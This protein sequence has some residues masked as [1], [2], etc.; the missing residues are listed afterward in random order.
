MTAGAEPSPPGRTPR[1]V[2][3]DLARAALV[4]LTALAVSPGCAGSAARTGSDAPGG[5]GPQAEPG[6]EAA[7]LAAGPR[8]T[9]SYVAA[10]VRVVVAA[11]ASQ[12]GI[13]IDIDGDVDVDRDLVDPDFDRRDFVDPDFDPDFDRDVEGD[14]GGRRDT[15]REEAPRSW[16]RLHVE[17]DAGGRRVTTALADRPWDEALAAI[18]CAAGLQVVERA[19][20]LVAGEAPTGGAPWSPR[21]GA[22][23][24]SGADRPGTT[25]APG[26]FAAALATPID[27]DLVDASLP[28]A[29]VA[30]ERASG[31]PFAAAPGLE[32]TVTLR[33]QGIPVGE[34]AKL[35][36]QLVGCAIVREPGAP[37]TF[38]PRECG[39]TIQ[40]G[41]ADRAVLLALV[42]GYAEVPLVVGP[43]PE[44]PEVAD[45]ASVTLWGR[46]DREAVVDLA[47][48]AGLV[49]ELR[50][51]VVL[52]GRVPRGWGAPIEPRADR[53]PVPPPEARLTVLAAGVDPHTLLKL[54][55]E[56]VGHDAIIVGGAPR[57][58]LRLD[59]LTTGEAIEA[60]GT[61][62]GLAG[63]LR[64]NR[65]LLRGPSIA[66]TRRPGGAP[67][68]APPPGGRPFEVRLGPTASRALHL[69][70]L[71]V[72]ESDGLPPSAVVSGCVL[73]P[74]ESFPRPL[75]RRTGD[76][77]ALFQ[78]LAITREGLEVLVPG[79]GERVVVPW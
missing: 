28:E 70:A 38:A 13:A 17:G 41:R 43:D 3:T 34:A 33:L 61:S 71:V 59:G 55:A 73:R 66:M 53:G 9:L 12:A 62:A 46:I 27:L 57:L 16:R 69:Q 47:H 21:P 58:D 18:T 56:Q 72:P 20:R 74:G 65:Y 79:T 50:G 14:A 32:G 4:A 45:E 63:E 35:I 25:R 7:G 22:F 29:A 68:P 36:A 75:S 64:G 78:V 15:T 11:L 40:L 26:A 2:V 24:A 23:G 39:T 42:A 6:G 67:G 8:V 77:E 60:V 1:R 48:A 51:E 54:L 19:G 5:P 10:P 30:L 49:A 52:V 31:V 37:S 44:G 76:D